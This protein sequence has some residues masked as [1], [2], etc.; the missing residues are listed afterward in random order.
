[1][2]NKYICYLI[3]RNHVYRDNGIDV[4]LLSVVYGNLWS[5]YYSSSYLSIYITL[6]IRNVDERPME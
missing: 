1:M 5:N 3:F 6:A 4:E 2:G